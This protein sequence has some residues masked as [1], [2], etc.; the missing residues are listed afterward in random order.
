MCYDN[1]YFERTIKVRKQLTKSIYNYSQQNTNTYPMACSQNSDT[2]GELDDSN[3]VTDMTDKHDTVKFDTKY[4]LNR[5]THNQQC[6]D[7]NETS[8]PS[9]Q[10]NQQI[11]VEIP[12]APRYQ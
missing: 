4:N 9:V 3:K 11:S 6:L 1:C 12:K 5:K 10:L 8:I 2:T 7:F